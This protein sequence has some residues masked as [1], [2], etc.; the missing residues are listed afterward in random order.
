MLL[1]QVVN[2]DAPS[3]RKLNATIPRDVETN[4]LK[5]LEKNP[6]GRYQTA[7]ELADDLRR[8]LNGEPILA[9]PINAAERVWKWAVRRPLVASI[10][11][12]L[13]L[14]ILL[15]LAG[16][17]WQ[18]RRAPAGQSATACDDSTGPDST[19]GTSRAVEAA[20][21]GLKE[22]RQWTDP[23]LQVM[24]LKLGTSRVRTLS[25]SAGSDE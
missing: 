2:D 25:L 5:C 4:R 6:A 1:H 18:W 24:S 13:A 19:R 17:T 7:T 8:F 15:G 9:R 22:F 16:V 20:I 23:A 11:T 14:T 10:L 12:A 3:P 21:A